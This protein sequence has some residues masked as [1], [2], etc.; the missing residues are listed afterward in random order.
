MHLDSETVVSRQHLLLNTISRARGILHLGAHK[1]QEAAVYAAA[2]KSVVWVEALP[3]I[4]QELSKNVSAFANQMALCALLDEVDGRQRVLG[5]SNNMDGVSSSV[6]DFGP[7]GQGPNSL[8]PDLDLQMVASVTLTGISLDT[9]L[10]ANNINAQNYDHWIVDLQGAELLALRGG[11]ESLSMCQ[12]LLIEVSQVPVYDGG[13]LWQELNN[14]LGEQGFEAAWDPL[15]Q[16]DDV[17]FISR[18]KLNQVRDEFH[19]DH[20]LSHN[21]RRLEHLSSLNIPFHGMR[22]LEVGAGIGDHTSFYVD[23]GCTVMSTEGRTE[24]LMLLRQRWASQSRVSVRMLDMDHPV[25]PESATFDLIH[26][27]GLLYHLNNPA[28]AICFM[29]KHGQMLVLETCVSLDEGMDI[30]HVNEPLNSPS[31]ALHG[32][33]CRPHE[34]WVLQTLREYFHEAFVTPKQPDHPE[35]DRNEALTKGGLFRRVFIARHPRSSDF[36]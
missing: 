35:F 17:L 22:V 25:L 28:E 9:L 18:S 29:S 12:S 26:C 6:F 19:S 1:G 34:T 10:N 31:Q 23:R 14:W 24:N 5:V 3:N 16:H 13:V 27:Y 21:A 7:Y 30:N 8:W 11:V 2:D 33:G 4:H 32:I 36:K 20:Y 15:L